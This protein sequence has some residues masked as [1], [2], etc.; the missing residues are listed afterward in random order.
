MF[1][2]FRGGSAMKR[3]VFTIIMLAT[4]PGVSSAQVKPK[5]WFGLVETQVAME[6]GSKISQGLFSLTANYQP[7]RFGFIITTDHQRFF[8][9]GSNWGETTAGLSLATEKKDLVFSVGPGYDYQAK[10]IRGRANLYY[11]NKARHF[12]YGQFDIGRDGTWWWIDGVAFLSP[13]FGFGFLGQ[14]PDL[15]IGPKIQV[16][17][18]P[19]ISF[20]V[21]GLKDPRANGPWYL[22]LSARVS[23]GRLGERGK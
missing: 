7:S 11:K 3:L 9:D 23:L 2:I 18:H 12:I 4:I 5:P 8:D 15:G 10:T 20:A 17:A 6:G 13:H 1:T 22:A 14:M 19:Q 21:A 16:R